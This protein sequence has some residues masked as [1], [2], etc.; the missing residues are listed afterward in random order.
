MSSSFSPTRTSVLLTIREEKKAPFVKQHAIDHKLSFER[1]L[2]M[3]WN[4]EEDAFLYTIT[5]KDK[6]LTR[7]GILSVT[8]AL[9]NSLVLVSPVT[10]TPKLLL[11]EACRMK[12][13]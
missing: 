10:L 6:P 13:D 11:Q 4:V 3:K 5:P 1:A 12:L 8:S 7:R 9:Y 2:G